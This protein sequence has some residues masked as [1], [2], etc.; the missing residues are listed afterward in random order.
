[1]HLTLSTWT[2]PTFSKSGITCLF[3]STAKLIDLSDSSLQNTSTLEWD[4]SD[5]FLYCKT[6]C[7]ITTLTSSL[8]CLQEFKNSQVRDH[9]RA[10]KAQRTLMEL[11][12]HTVSSRTISVH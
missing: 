9:M 4:S 1:M 3:S 2:I 6:K 5:S 10:K 12:L 8:R 11:I 7:P